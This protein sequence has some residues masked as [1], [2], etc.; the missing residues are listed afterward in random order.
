MA[1]TA[2]ITTFTC[3]PGSYQEFDIFNRD[4]CILREV[5]RKCQGKFN[6]TLKFY[7]ISF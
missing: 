4:T 7:F 6:L 5:H 3:R 1:K 2:K